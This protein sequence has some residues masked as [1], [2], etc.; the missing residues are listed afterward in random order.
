MRNK[1]VLK[2]KTC[3]KRRNETYTRYR[4]LVLSSIVQNDKSA[5]TPG[6]QLFS[7][8]QTGNTPEFMILVFYKQGSKRSS[9]NN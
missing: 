6:N 3:P 2:T 8:L 4:N 5:D 9:N 7:L 1:S